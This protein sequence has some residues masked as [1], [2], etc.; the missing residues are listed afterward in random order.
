MF[1]IPS[2]SKRSRTS[3]LMRTPKEARMPRALGC[4]CLS[5]LTVSRSSRVLAWKM[6]FVAGLRTSRAKSARGPLPKKMISGLFI[7]TPESGVVFN[8]GVVVNWFEVTFVVHTEESFRIVFDV[9]DEED[10]V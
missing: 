7:F 6:M 5:C 4:S 8:F 1:K 9:V 2:G 10:A 3:C